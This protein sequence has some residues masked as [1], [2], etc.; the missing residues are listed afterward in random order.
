MLKLIRPDYVA[1][2]GQGLNYARPSETI[3]ELATPADRMAALET[4]THEVA[5]RLQMTALHQI[6]FG[7]PVFVAFGLTRNQAKTH[8]F[9]DLLLKLGSSLS[10]DCCPEY[11]PASGAE[12]PA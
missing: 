1:L 11:S 10:L 5:R 6:K 4:A 2:D 7:T 8:A 9:S 12:Q 3:D